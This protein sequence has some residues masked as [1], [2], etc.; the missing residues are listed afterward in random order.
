MVTDNI[1]SPVNACKALDDFLTL[2]L[3]VDQK[4]E[5][6]RKVIII[7]LWISIENLADG[8]EVIDGV[9]LVL[10]SFMNRF[11]HRFDAAATH[12]AHVV[13]LVIDI[14]SY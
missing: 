3:M 11:T 7:R 5:W 12:A 1:F 6:A 10:D 8:P 4:I 2:R 9:R 13:S 14:L